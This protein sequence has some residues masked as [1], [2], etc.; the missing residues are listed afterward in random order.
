VKIFL[1]VLMLAVAAPCSAQTSSIT[2]EPVAVSLRY[3]PAALGA[4]V[5]AGVEVMAGPQYAVNVNDAVTRDARSWAGAYATV[6]LRSSA[7]L[8]VNVSPAGVALVVGNDYAAAYPS[9]QLGVE[10]GRGRVSFGTLVRV[11][12]VPTVNSSATYW[13]RW[14]PL[15]VS[16]SL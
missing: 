1:A 9:A 10:Y 16:Y 3:L 12:R 8:S 11:I 6:Q 15:R 5:R 7:G 14:V 2:V 13:T 4:S